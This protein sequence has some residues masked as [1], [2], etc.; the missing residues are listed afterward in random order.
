MEPWPVNSAFPRAT[1]SGELGIAGGI[2]MGLR[3]RENAVENDFTCCTTAAS[4]S[5]VS[6]PSKY[7]IALA[8]RPSRTV[9]MRS[10]SVGGSSAAV[11]LYLKTPDEKSRG[12]GNI[13]G[14]AGPFPFPSGPW[15]TAHRCANALAPKGV[16]WSKSAPG[17][18]VR[19]AYCAGSGRYSVVGTASA[20]RAQM[21]RPTRAAQ[22]RRSV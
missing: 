15:Q 19:S 22:R 14:A 17:G 4:S 9:R 5:A 12:R 8:G 16:P 11:D 1:L 21:E 3:A 2:S 18:H 7:G 13:D 6:S 10:S 20:T